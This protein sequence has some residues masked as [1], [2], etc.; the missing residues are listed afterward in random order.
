MNNISN[1]KLAL[2]FTL[3]KEGGYVN[4]PND[5]GGET[6]WGIS[7]RFHP[8]LDIR[9]LTPEQAAGIYQTEYWDKVGCDQIPFPECVAV[10]DTA[11]NCGVSRTLGWLK[12][13]TDTTDF[14]SKRSLY[15]A[16]LVTNTPADKKFLNGWINRVNDLKKYIDSISND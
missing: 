16:T 8:N 12:N 13:A 9:N 15:Y 3:S 11:V 10:F 2:Q 14:L 7:K 4:D 5:P 1:F 6:K